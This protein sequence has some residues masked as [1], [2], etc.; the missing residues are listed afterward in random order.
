MKMKKNYNPFSISVIMPALNEADNI[1]DAIYSTLKAFD[2]YNIDGD[3]IVI[4]DGSMD[5]TPVIVQKIMKKEARVKLINH[6]KPM[7][8]GYSFFDGVKHS[9]K[10]TVIM[11]PGDNEN[12]PEDALAYLDLMEQVDIIVPFIYNIEMRKRIRRIVS[13]IY[14]FIINVSFGI[15]LNYSNG[16]VLYR[17]C[18]MDNITLRSHGFFYQAELLIK[19]IRRGYMFAEVPNFLSARLSGKSKATTLKS[20]LRVIKSYIRLVLD[21]HVIRIEGRKD[22]HRLHKDSVSYKKSTANNLIEYVA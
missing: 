5:D 2:N 20:L 17:R 19:L 9:S 7:G 4:N 12:N 11:V 10:D 1:Q 18:I 13:S 14:R 6:T 16:T 3:I 21:I 22:Y 8:I 15:N